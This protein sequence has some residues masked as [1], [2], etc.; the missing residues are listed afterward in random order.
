MADAF[1]GIRDIARCRTVK[2]LFLHAN[3]LS[4]MQKYKEFSKRNEMEHLEM[5][6]MK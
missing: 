4:P 2:V 5:T 3:V 1:K 6:Y